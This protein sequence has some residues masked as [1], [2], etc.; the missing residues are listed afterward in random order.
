M[1]R[2]RDMA[3]LGSSASEGNLGGKNLIINGGMQVSQRSTS[4]SGITSTG[5]H[6]LDRWRWAESSD[7]TVTISQSTDTPT[8]QGFKNSLKVDVTTADASIAAAQY[9]HI[10][11]S[12]EAQNCH[13]LR[14][15][16]S[17]AKTLTLSFW[18]KST[19]TG[20]YCIAVQKDDSTRYD[21]IAEYTIS[22]ADTWEKKTITIV[23]DS[24]IKA[25]GGV[26]DN[27]NGIGLKLKW[28]L[29]VGTD[30][31]GTNNTWNS[32][33]PADAT[34]NQ[35]NFLDNTSNDFYLTGCQLELGTAATD[36]EHESFSDTLNKCLRYHFK[37]MRNQNY[38]EFALLRTYSSTNGTG[39]FPLPVPMRANPTL[40]INQTVNSTNFGYSLSSLTIGSSDVNTHSHTY[41]LAEGGF[42]ANGAAVIQKMNDTNETA[43]SFDAEL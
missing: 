41:L 43:L 42:T 20:T 8:G 6:A 17:S 37:C 27:N 21:Y 39:D 34:S 36:F 32:S 26:I 19:K 38:G 13:S 28:T 10:Q 7:A 31:D 40:S 24:N 2:A 35:V 18:V 5:Y 33:T 16:S 9:A 1:S 15:G 22:S 11:H 23:P 4:A 14:Y 12:I 25:A 3:N 29:A 30:R